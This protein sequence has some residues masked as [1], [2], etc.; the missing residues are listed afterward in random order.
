LAW[1]GLAWLG[2]AWLGLAW[3][4]LAWLGLAWLGLAWLG[5]IR[6]IPTDPGRWNRH[7]VPKR[8]LIKFRRQ[9]NSQKTILY[10]YNTAK[11]KNYKSDRVLRPS[12][13]SNGLISLLFNNLELRFYNMY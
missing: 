6:I 13:S 7:R 4:G 10:N 3:L 11:V 2:L 9:G 1:L 12:L 5:L 8:C